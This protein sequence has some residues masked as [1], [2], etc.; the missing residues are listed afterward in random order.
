MVAYARRKLLGGERQAVFHCWTRCVR[1]AFLCGRD[2]QTRKDYSHRRDWIVRREEQLAGLFAIEI[3][4]RAE[5]SNHLH[6]VLRTLPRVA[7][8]WSAQEVA[9]R[10]L[11]ITKLAKCLSDDL[12]QPD[13]HRV[14]QLAKDKKT[15]DKLRRRLSNVSWYMGIL[16]E[17]IARRANAEDDCTGRFWE[18]RYRCRE[19]TDASAILLCGIYVDLNPYRAGEVDIPEASRYTSVFQR[20]Q[21]QGMRK[22]AADRP[23]GWLGELTLLPERKVD[24]ALAHSSRTGRRASDMGILPVSL[25]AYVKLL[26]WTAQQLRSGHRD[27]D[28][29]GPGRGAGSP[30][31]PAG[32]V[33]RERG[34]VRVRVRAC[35]RPCRLAGRGRCTNGAQTSERRFRLPQRFHVTK[36]WHP[37]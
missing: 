31:R 8:R 36:R 29:A 32:R 7:R 35:G 4:F 26:K 9:R 11:T 33:A 18:T 1:R 28:S 23:E 19:C 15:I 3:E 2:P 16:C 30:G 13:P 22:N 27:H 10:W 5:M 20:L 34:R 14:E 24:E 25:E 37:H 21:A 17:N 6:N 12:P